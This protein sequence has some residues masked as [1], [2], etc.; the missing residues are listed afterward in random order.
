MKLRFV[1]LALL[2]GL[3]SGLVGCNEEDTTLKNQRTFIERYLTSGHQPR[4]VS[5]ET[6]EESGDTEFYD[7]WGLNT[8]RYIATMYEEGREDKPI[9]EMGD[10][11]ELVLTAYIFSGSTPRD[12]AI[13]FTNNP[14]KIA[15]L[16]KKGLNPEFWSE[17]PL[18]INLG[19]TNIIKGV[20]KAL[21]GCR[22]GDE[23]EIY[24][25]FVTGYDDLAVGMVPKDS[26]VAWML[27]ISSVRKGR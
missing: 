6:A 3:C 25:T 10:E 16:T 17:E 8:Y 4:L 2:V 21:V 18:V 27:T 7:V 19:T 24:M 5:R 11:V 22:E 13:Y 1:I 12:D 20:E 26:S 23:V 15:A 9:V 14:V